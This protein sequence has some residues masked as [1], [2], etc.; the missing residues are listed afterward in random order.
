[1]RWK[2]E[3]VSGE[4]EGWK[5]KAQNNPGVFKSRCIYE[6]CISTHQL[7]VLV[8]RCLCDCDSA[9]WPRPSGGA[10]AHFSASYMCTCTHVY[11]YDESPSLPGR[12][13]LLLSVKAVS[14]ALSRREGF[15]VFCLAA[16]AYERYCHVGVCVYFS[17]K[18][19]LNAPP[20]SMNRF[21]KCSV[22]D[23]RGRWWA[24]W[25]MTASTCGT[26]GRRGRPSFTPS[27]STEKGE[28]CAH[29]LTPRHLAQLLAL[30]FSNLTERFKDPS[31]HLSKEDVW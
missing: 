15:A 22:C 23:H 17:T 8:C 29:P 30:S 26:W 2:Q 4:R 6:K 31:L 1:M 13:C 11:T 21:F 24:L 3:R 12:C 28:W 25:L 16:N 5:K 9:A 27:S 7:F 20:P 18:L 19:T 14:H 10:G